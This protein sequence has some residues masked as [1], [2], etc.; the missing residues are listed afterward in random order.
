MGLAMGETFIITLIT[1]S[2]V[3]EALESHKGAMKSSS[4]LAPSEH[5]RYIDDRNG[6]L[7]EE[8][9]LVIIECRGCCLSICPPTIF[10][11]T[12]LPLSAYPL[13]RHYELS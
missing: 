8:Q 3:G 2:T 4:H 11:P 5:L 13:P 1:V 10:S 9:H 12:Y 7:K 6:Y